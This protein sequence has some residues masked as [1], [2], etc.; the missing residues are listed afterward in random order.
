MLRELM[1]NHHVT[2][3]ALCQETLDAA[4]KKRA[5]EY[6]HEQK[7]VPWRET[8]KGT[9]RFFL[10]LGSNLISP[11]PYVIQKYRSAAMT[12]AIRRL[13][14]TERFDIVVCDF[15]SPAVNLVTLRPRPPVK[16]LLF[17]HNVES[18]IW[19]RMRDTA[20]GPI[21]RV[22]FAE[23][24]RR[25]L[26]F[27]REA[28]SWFD[29]V[30]GVSEED[31]KMMREKLGLGNVLG[32][33]PTGVDADFFHPTTVAKTPHSMVFLGSMD[34][35]PNIDAVVYFADAIFPL[36][37][38]SVPE[39]TLTIVG[40][41]PP[42]RVRELAKNDPAVR[43]TGTVDD[44]RPFVAA[45]EAVVV[46]LR[47]GGG[48]RIKIFEAMAAG[49]PVVSTTIGAEGLPVKH[50]EHILL[51]DNPDSFS[52][53]TARLLRNAELRKKIGAN[54]QKLVREQFS[55]ESATKVFE[56]YCRKL[57]KPHRF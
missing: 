28:A 33:V 18:Q 25:M 40:R 19:E 37:K 9:P 55:W 7:W 35:M 44:V 50:D 52:D 1:K 57:Q 45:A 38:N 6:S 41:N 39:A 13:V 56:N 17:Q 42:E 24:W 14:S 49:V 15:L 12:S 3:L 11:L 48:T 54:G 22:Y 32:S 46:P 43:V 47:V 21:R 51:A 16:M 4:V 5:S 30:I 8:P 36:I 26:R 27:E 34:W 29:G 53:C 31:C 2:Y 20:N 10:E 23:Q